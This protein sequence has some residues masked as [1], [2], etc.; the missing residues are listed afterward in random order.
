M[1]KSTIMGCLYSPRKFQYSS[2][3]SLDES[4]NQV[5]KLCEEEKSVC[6]TGDMNARSR[7]LSDVYFDKNVT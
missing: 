1:D 2:V 7:N 5:V 3:E 4:E 6:I